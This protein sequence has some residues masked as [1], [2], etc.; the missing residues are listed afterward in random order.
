[1]AIVMTLSFM[2]FQKKLE[3]T[4]NEKIA[5]ILNL[6]NKEYPKV[7]QYDIA[8]IMKKASKGNTGNILSKYG[9]EVDSSFWIKEEKTITMVFLVWM[10]GA[11]I[12]TVL[13][14]EL[15][16][17]IYN[18]KKDMEIN[19]I[20][21]LIEAINHKN[22]SL[23]IDSLSEDE[24]SILKNEIYKTTIFLK[25]NAENSVRDKENLKKSLQDISHQLKT[26]LTSILINL[27]NVMKDDEMK[28][29]VRFGFLRQIRRDTESM[30]FMIQT[31]LKLSKFETN[32][33]TFNQN[34]V[35]LVEIIDEA[36]DNVAALSDL[37]NVDIEKKINEDIDLYCDRTWMCEALKN[38][39]KNA[40][41]HSPGGSSVEISVSKNK[42]YTEISIAD[43]GIGISKKDISHI[44][45]RFYKDQDASS[46]SVGIGLA[47]SRDII[48]SQNGKI[49]VQSEPRC[50]TTF[51]VQIF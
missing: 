39:L 40:V 14:I 10:L 26:P 27:E 45:E 20:T 25:E 23:E 12:I 38:I 50:G 46:D 24:L 8:K 31:L 13:C 1:M 44:F 9:Y 5:N 2:L 21:K 33:I 48:E 49:R 16:F 36:I 28:P 37:R 34:N 43:H 18:K 51:F 29:E 42:L 19:D 32:T 11:V 30:N 47:L 3:H 15:I 4:E 6:V 35:K 17:L 22:Y 41:E 7:Q